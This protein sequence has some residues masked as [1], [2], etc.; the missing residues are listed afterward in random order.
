MYTE[1]FH[2]SCFVYFDIIQTEDRRP[3][4]YAEILIAKLQISNRNI[5]YPGLA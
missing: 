1:I 3:E 2:C 4:Q 5:S